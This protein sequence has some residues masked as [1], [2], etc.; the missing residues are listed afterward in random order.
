MFNIDDCRLFYAEEVQAA[1][2]VRSQALV[3]AFGRVP[4]ER[5]LGHGPW[6]VAVPDAVSGRVGYV[7]TVDDDPRR[8]YHNVLISL[9]RSHD[10]N[11][12]QPATLAQYIDALEVAA[13]DRVYH[14]GAGTG[15]Y[16]AII[17]ELVGSGG[18]M[19]AVEIHPELGNSA[20]LN[21]QTA[22]T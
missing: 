1:G 10:L 11:N 15:Y 14:L 20:K 13:G 4:R 21:W 22:P 7:P 18:E 16:T 3:G 6:Y 17:A 2:N 12:G 19:V 9:D 5:F 8:V